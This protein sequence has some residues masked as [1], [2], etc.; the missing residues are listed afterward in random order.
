LPFVAIQSLPVVI[1]S[2]HLNSSAGLGSLLQIVNNLC[3]ELSLLLSQMHNPCGLYFLTV[4]RL[5]RVA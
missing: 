4:M 1:Q 2:R 3:R 5:T